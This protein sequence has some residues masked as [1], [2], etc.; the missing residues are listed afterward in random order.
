MS[1]K[2]TPPLNISGNFETFKIKELKVYLARNDIDQKIILEASPWFLNLFRHECLSEL[3]Q[4]YAY[5]TWRSDAKWLTCGDMVLIVDDC[6]VKRNQ[7]WLVRVN[8]LIIGQGVEVR[9]SRS[10]KILKK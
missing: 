3:S 1:R 8:N 10:Q 2:L 4:I 9:L 7:W 5:N 6:K